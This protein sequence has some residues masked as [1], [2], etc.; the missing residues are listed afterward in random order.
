V[1]G[2]IFVLVAALIA[3][4]AVRAVAHDVVEIHVNG[5]YFAEP[6]TVR[7]TVAVEPDSANRMLRIEADSDRMFRA[8]EVE[9]EGLTDKRIH[10][11]EFK[12]LPAGAYE[13]RAEVMS[14]EKVLGMAT[15]DVVVEGSGAR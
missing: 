6:A 8:T 4:A 14:K 10:T 7:I 2:R 1:K 12:N 15:S 9:L 3:V 5:Y 13:L 11:F